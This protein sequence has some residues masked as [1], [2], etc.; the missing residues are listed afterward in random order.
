MVA[1][2]LSLSVLVSVEASQQTTQSQILG[3]R[4]NALLGARVAIGKL[5]KTIGP[6]NILTSNAS[7]AANPV[8]EKSKWL[9]VL[10][11]DGTGSISWLV[12]GNENP[13]TN[14][15]AA[16]STKL[17]G[18][19]ATRV[20]QVPV[21]TSLNEGNFSFWVSDLSQKAR[22]DL[23]DS[24][25]T[26]TDY[27]IPDDSSLLAPQT[28][29]IPL[30]ADLSPLASLGEKT[31]AGAELR[32]RAK[33]ATQYAEFGH[34]VPPQALV[35]HFHN[36]T[37]FSYGLFTNVVDGG[38][39]TDL[40]TYVT[41]TASPLTDIYT[42]GPPWAL[43]QDFL[44]LGQS[45]DV[46]GITPAV[47]NPLTTAGAQDL[48]HPNSHGIV[49]VIFFWQ[50]GM[51]VVPQPPQ[52]Y[53]PDDTIPLALR[54]EPVVIMLNPYNVPLK[55][56]TYVLRML[57]GGGSY[58]PSTNTQREPALVLEHESHSG[59]KTI[60]TP[61]TGDANGV[62]N[63]GNYLNEWLPDFTGHGSGSDGRSFQENSFRVG[64]TTSFEPGQIKVFALESDTTLPGAGEDWVL[65][66]QEVDDPLTPYFATSGD[67]TSSLQEPL[68]GRMYDQ[69]LAGSHDLNLKL[70][71]GSV[72]MSLYLGSVDNE[73]PVRSENLTTTQR[74][75]YDS[76]WS[77]DESYFIGSYLKGPNDW[78]NKEDD[79]PSHEGLSSLRNY[80]LRSHYQHQTHPNSAGV[81]D[82]KQSPTYSPFSDIA[83]QYNGVFSLWDP[84][85]FDS[86]T[87]EPRLVLFQLPTEPITSLA[88]LQHVDFSHHVYAPAYA[89][90]NSN[91][92]PWIPASETRSTTSGIQ[93][94]SYLLNEAL[95]DHF[96]VSTLE[97]DGSGNL[98][99]ASPRT[100]LYARNGTPPS[101][102]DLSDPRSAASH[103]LLEG[104]F[105]VNSD[106]VDAWTALLASG[107]QFPTK[108]RDAISGDQDLLD[109]Q[110]SPYGRHS[111]PSGGS[112][113]LAPPPDSSAEYWRG[114]RDLTD[115]QIRNLAGQIVYRIR[116]KGPFNRLADFINRDPSSNLQVE[117][118]SGILQAAIDS[119]VVVT[120]DGVDFNPPNINPAPNSGNAV[121]SVHEDLDYEFPEAALGVRSS[122]APGYLSQAD[123]LAKLGPY[124]TVRGDSFLIRA[125]GE[126][127][128]GFGEASRTSAQCEIIVQ[129]VPEY[130]LDPTQDPTEPANATNAIMGRKLQVISFRWIDEEML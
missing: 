88:E 84:A 73:N 54:M 45:V 69:I 16:T 81:T 70:L 71:A 87:L 86:D 62:Q 123:L 25:I 56:Q 99:P 31:P 32:T 130:L 124:L 55:S 128:N 8:P 37:A 77:S 7:L 107:Y 121:Q 97:D 96:F 127:T 74:I 2:L 53:G 120:V 3:A 43:Y 19:G 49:P 63:Y 102:T 26:A 27:D 122:M 50:F 47:R 116:Q 41:D 5:Q 92:N 68:T 118:L 108:V 1:I 104:P 114:Y 23:T 39:K 89:V 79:P 113:S 64:F 80:N 119:Q 110:G 66:L 57:S 35:D 83:S 13:E 52:T 101:N 76:E 117:Q 40:T 17:P 51:S 78:V 21:Q 103:L 111:I 75:G 60:L 61:N 126:N 129:R 85:M 125:S 14:S 11:S 58:F 18:F 90:G 30:L 65:E 98:I 24:R 33:S 44:R 93:D 20:P 34:L 106:S 4:T 46:N 22:I 15:N 42:N 36:L 82:F 9:G 28:F 100:T 72:V 48:A 59:S 67:I 112:V 109:N 29:G 95:W 91:A 94:Y 115:Q 12:S 38:L 10:P 105:N 6:D